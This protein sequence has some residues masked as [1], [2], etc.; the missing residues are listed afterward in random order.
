MRI[1]AN[2]RAQANGAKRRTVGA[3]IVDGGRSL[4]KKGNLLGWVGESGR[5]G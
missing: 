4:K 5:G 2:L 3:K 1:E